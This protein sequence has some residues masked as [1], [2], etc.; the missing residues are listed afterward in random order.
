MKRNRR[1]REREDE[2]DN[3]REGEKR[4]QEKKSRRI[5]EKEIR[6]EEET[7]SPAY[8]MLVETANSNFWLTHR[9]SVGTSSASGFYFYFQCILPQYSCIQFFT[10]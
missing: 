1:R 8:L 7:E 9:G 10:W 4:E 6:R 3:R 5:G 2:Q